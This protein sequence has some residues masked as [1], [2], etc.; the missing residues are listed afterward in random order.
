TIARAQRL[1]EPDLSSAFG[2]ADQ[3]DVHHP[4]AS[5]SQREYSDE[6]EDQAQRDSKLLNLLRIFHG[7]PLGTGLVVFGIE[8]VAP[9]QHFPHLSERRR[10]T[11]RR[12]WLEN[13]HLWIALVVDISQAL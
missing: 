3:H 5:N 8:I 2:D 6:P 11:I 13:N 1:A 10:M 4:D 12:D 9:G 7:V